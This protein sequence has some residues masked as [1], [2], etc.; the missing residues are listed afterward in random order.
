M[1]FSLRL[2]STTNIFSVV[3]EI[4]FS[5]LDLSSTAFA[6]YWEKFLTLDYFYSALAKREKK[7]QVETTDCI[8]L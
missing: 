5:S 2:R 4:I 6:L 1:T 8:F 3:D 7:K